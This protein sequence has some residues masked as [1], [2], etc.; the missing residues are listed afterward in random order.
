MA[1]NTYPIFSKVGDIQWNS[2]AATTAN[3]TIDLTSGTIY[4]A[5]T[6]DATNGGYVQ[7]V[8][9][10]SLGTNSSANVAR[11]WIN[12]GSSTGSAANNI[13]WDEVSIPTTTVSQTASLPVIE[14]P[15]NFALPPGYKIYV[16]LGTTVSAGYHIAVIGGKF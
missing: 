9:F 2:G 6:A 7:R 1:G 8:R 3:T 16:T 5:F 12:N 4:L 11:I 13:M 15:L 14:V 10:R